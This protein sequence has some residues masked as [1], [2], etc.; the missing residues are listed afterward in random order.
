MFTAASSL[1]IAAALTAGVSAGTS[2]AGME[3]RAEC[4]SNPGMARMHEELSAGNP[5]MAQMHEQM[6]TGSQGAS[7]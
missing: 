5:G 2:P 3:L 4:D 6:M 7:R 1:A